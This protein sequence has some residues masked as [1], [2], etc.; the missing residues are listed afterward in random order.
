M[1]QDWKVVVGL[2]AALLL[3]ISLQSA[4]HAA[5]SLTPGNV[6]QPGDENV[7]MSTLLPPN[8]LALGFTNASGHPVAF[9]STLDLL[10]APS[11]GQSRLEFDR[12]RDQRGG[13]PTGS[14]SVVLIDHLQPGRRGDHSDRR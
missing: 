13:D 11:G 2:T 6:P 4:S 3:F 9:F 10:F 12:R 1:F 5:I 7:L 14:L 8:S